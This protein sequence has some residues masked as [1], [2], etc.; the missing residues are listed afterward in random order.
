MK[1]PEAWT[2]MYV[3]NYTMLFNQTN[4]ALY[5]THSTQNTNNEKNTIFSMVSY[6]CHSYQPWFNNNIDPS[7]YSKLNIKVSYTKKH[8]YKQYRIPN[9]TV[10]ELQLVYFTVPHQPIMP[11]Y[12]QLCLLSN[13]NLLLVPGH[14]CLK[15][16]KF[17]THKT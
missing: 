9:V 13:V 17:L 12:Q 4:W 6:W 10:S 1:T 16:V 2:Y 11:P 8:D 7:A 5:E 15:R 3:K 14:S